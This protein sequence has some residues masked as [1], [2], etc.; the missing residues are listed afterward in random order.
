MN[1][2]A[3]QTRLRASLDA[4]TAVL[5]S[6]ALGIWVA[7]WYGE[8]TVVGLA[9]VGM[10]LILVTTAAV[11]IVRRRPAFST[12]A[13]RVTLIRAVLAGGCATVLTL[14]LVDSAPPRSWL[15][16]ALAAPA[17]LL[18]AVDGWVARRT[19]TANTHGARLD[20]ETDAAFLMILSIPVALTVGPW[21][22]A[23]GGMR[24]LFWA[25]SWWRPALKQ[26]LE[27]SQFRRVIAGL[28]GVALVFAL[29]PL[30]PAPLAAL[31]T[32]LALA[33]LVLSFGRDVVFLERTFKGR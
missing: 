5:G 18:D 29:I 16:F 13:D 22:L 12:P 15:L 33:L 4:A 24:Y 20:M 30:V 3:R 21:A 19:A 2:S 9:A 32:A 8:V 23:I 25:A 28:Q 11:S 14:T 17:L 7:R 10:G 26:K 6:L 31:T 27:F 1:V